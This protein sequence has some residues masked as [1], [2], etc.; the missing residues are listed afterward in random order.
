MCLRPSHHR[1]HVADEDPQGDDPWTRGIGQATRQAL[2]QTSASDAMASDTGQWHVPLR[3]CNGRKKERRS[4]D[5][6]SQGG[7]LE[8][9]RQPIPTGRRNGSIPYSISAKKGIGTRGLAQQTAGCY[10]FVVIGPA[11]V[12]PIDTRRPMR[13][14]ARTDL[15]RRDPIGDSQTLEIPHQHSRHAAHRDYKKSL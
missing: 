1:P 4:Q 7:R 11:G 6:T 8:P 2:S 12:Q 13:N 3:I 15:G 14:T 9:I 5:K 10:I